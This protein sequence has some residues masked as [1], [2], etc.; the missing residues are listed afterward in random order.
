[1]YAIFLIFV[2]SKLFYINLPIY[3]ISNNM[4]KLIVLV[5]HSNNYYNKFIRNNSTSYKIK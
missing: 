3:L 1:M 4:F 5:L 2:V